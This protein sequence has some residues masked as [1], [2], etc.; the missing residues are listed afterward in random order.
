[1]IKYLSQSVASH[2]SFTDPLVT[3]GMEVDESFYSKSQI[4]S[5]ELCNKEYQITSY[6]DISLEHVENMLM[7][8]LIIQNKRSL[9]TMFLDI[10]S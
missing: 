2:T 5:T 9:P 3:I 7:K 4:T 6:T 8:A 1:M 10:I